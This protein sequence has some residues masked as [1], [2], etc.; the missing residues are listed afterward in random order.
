MNLEFC[1]FRLG[2]QSISRYFLLEYGDGRT[3]LF[4]Q[5][6]RGKSQ[7]PK[8]G[9]MVVTGAVGSGDESKETLKDG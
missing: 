1:Y 8:S 4:F 5:G 2:R 6:E 9:S 7:I 3:I